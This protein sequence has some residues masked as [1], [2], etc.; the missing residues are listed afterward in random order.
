MI[1]CQNF[2][3]MGSVSSN[4]M[5]TDVACTLDVPMY[6]FG[7]M[8]MALTPNDGCQFIK[9]LYDCMMTIKLQRSEVTMEII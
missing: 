7:L 4:Q 1:T 6:E 9:C 8:E 3:T 5:P 2:A